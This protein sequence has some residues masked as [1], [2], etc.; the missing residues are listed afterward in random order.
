[1]AG[2]DQVVR[3]SNLSKE[4]YQDASLRIIFRMVVAARDIANLSRHQSH[5]VNDASLGVYWSGRRDLNSRP[6]VPQ[7]GVPR[8]A[9]ANAPLRLP[10]LPCGL[11]TPVPPRGLPARLSVGELLRGQSRRVAGGNGREGRAAQRT[12]RSKNRGR[13]LLLRNSPTSVSARRNL[14]G[15]GGEQ[16]CKYAERAS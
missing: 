4:A 16:Y 11:K 12:R 3:L 6:P 15:N 9:P 7:T 5:L 2:V 10:G 8:P 14:T 1:L 13:R